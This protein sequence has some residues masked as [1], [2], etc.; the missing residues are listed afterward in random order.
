MD[1]GGVTEGHPCRSPELRPQEEELPWGTVGA[2]QPN[3]DGRG[4]EKASQPDGKS[5]E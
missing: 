5:G 3:K 1:G 2:S 4:R